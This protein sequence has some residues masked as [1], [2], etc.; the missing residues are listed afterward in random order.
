[1]ALQAS[2]A[3]YDNVNANPACPVVLSSFPLCVV[4]Y[5]KPSLVSFV[6]AFIPSAELLSP[7]VGD[8]FFVASTL[9]TRVGSNSKKVKRKGKGVQDKKKRKAQSKPECPIHTV[10]ISSIGN[11][12]KEKD[13][14]V[15]G[16]TGNVDLTAALQAQ[17]T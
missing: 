7:E 1:M 13:C 8:R 12:K 10:S 14:T 2:F 4:C 6:D 9:L 17:I 11:T 3:H 16:F 15:R 5:S